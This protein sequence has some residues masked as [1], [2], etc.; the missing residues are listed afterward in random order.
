MSY[1]IPDLIESPTSA[2]RLNL[3]AQLLSVPFA[4]R[5]LHFTSALH[6]LAPGLAGDPPSWVGSWEEGFRPLGLWLTYPSTG[7]YAHFL[8]S[9]GPASDSDWHAPPRLGSYPLH[10]PAGSIPH[11]F[12]RGH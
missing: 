9:P 3:K 7:P 11:G 1:S 4:G 10:G 5:L 2:L 8:P 6:G 12:S